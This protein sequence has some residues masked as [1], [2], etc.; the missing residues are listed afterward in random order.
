M[1]ASTIT[2]PSAA[3]AVEVEHR[4]GI[5]AGQIITYIVLALLTAVFIGPL[6]FIW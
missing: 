1:S 2:V 4:R 3:P 6:L 5:T